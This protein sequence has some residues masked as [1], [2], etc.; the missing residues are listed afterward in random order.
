MGCYLATGVVDIADSRFWQ[1]AEGHRFTFR[2]ACIDTLILKASEIYWFYSRFDTF[3]LGIHFKYQTQLATTDTPDGTTRL[4]PSNTESSPAAA[5]VEKPQVSAPRGWASRTFESLG[6]RD[7]RLMWISMFLSMGGFNMLMLARGILIYDLTG[8]ALRTAIVSIGWAPGLLIM[9]LFG[10]VLGDRVERRMLIQLSQLANALFA[11]TVGTL[12]LTGLIEWWH[13]MIVSALQGCVFALQIPARTAAMSQLVP[14]ELIGNAMALNA[15]AMTLMSVAAPAVGG[16]LYEWIQPEGVYYV[17]AA[18]MFMAMAFTSLLPKMHP[19]Q[20]DSSAK[21]SPLVNIRRGLKYAMGHPIVRVLLLQSVVIAMLSMPFRML[22]PVFAKDLY[23]SLPSE[24]GLIATMAGVGGIAASIGVASLRAG[25]HRGWV[26]L[27]SPIISAVSIFTIGALPWYWVGMIMFVGV[28]FGE[29]I[30][31][32]LGQALVVEHADPRYRARMTSL[33]M[34]TYGLIPIAAFPV[35]WLVEN[36]GV[37]QTVMGMAIML[38][39]AGVIFILGSPSIRK[40][41]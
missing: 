31:W 20:S 15:T 1:V 29:S 41:S 6:N 37:E 39:L 27:M 4:T 33:T 30:R 21:E 2:F 14:K 34:M 19:D 32:A 35:G 24:V 12:I 10:G 23:G 22:V 11:V 28:G 40:L 13:L 38:M 3:K 26:I 8:D 17:V 7:Y 5:P 18:M 36:V 25:Q 9:S 16:I